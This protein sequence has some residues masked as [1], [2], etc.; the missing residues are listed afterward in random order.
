MI[1]NN[2]KWFTETRHVDV[3]TGEA[4]SKSKVEREKWLKVG[5]SHTTQDCGTYWLK[6]HT[7]EYE[8]SRQTKLEF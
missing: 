1:D 4:L 7:N 2:K 6:I 3:E 5:G 8:R